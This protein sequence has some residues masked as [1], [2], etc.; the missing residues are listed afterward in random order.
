M[1]DDNPTA[2]P[3]WSVSEAAKRAGVAR[4]T[5]Q[6]Y[7]AQGRMPGA[8]RTAD[9]VWSIG[10]EDLLAA[11]LMPD[12]PSPPDQAAEGVP[13]AHAQAPAGDGAEQA[14]RIAELEAELAETRR[15]ADVAEAIARERA[16]RIVDLRQTIAALEAGRSDRAPAPTPPPAP[17]PSPPA[18]R[19]RGL[20]ERVAGRFGL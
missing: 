3:R 16:D 19:S 13:H 11:G 20:L 1:T 7:L 12:R 6:R 14:R 17:E 4:S 9:G 5:V 8:Y 15:R 18:P 2:R 10:V